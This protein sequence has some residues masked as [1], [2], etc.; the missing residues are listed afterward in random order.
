MVPWP[1][2]K[3]ITINI[4][5]EDHPI[6]IGHLSLPAGPSPVIPIALESG[7]ELVVDFEGA[8]KER[9][10]ASLQRFINGSWYLTK[11]FYSLLETAGTPRLAGRLPGGLYRFTSDWD[12]KKWISPSFLVRPEE[13]RRRRKL[14][15]AVATTLRGTVTVPKDYHVE[16]VR[17]LRVGP[18][19]AGDFRG[20]RTGITSDARGRFTVHTLDSDS[21]TIQPWHPQL[22]PLEEQ[23]TVA[24]DPATEPT[25]LLL[26]GT[27]ASFRPELPL[28][29]RFLT[30]GRIRVLLLHADTDRIV[31]THEARRIGDR[32]IFG[33]F[34]PGRY[35]VWIDP[36]S[37]LKWREGSY[38]SIVRLR[39]PDGPATYEVEVVVSALDQ[40]R[41]VRRKRARGRSR[42]IVP[43]LR[44]GRFRVSLERPNGAGTQV[45][46]QEITSPG[47]GAVEVV[48]EL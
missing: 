15:L 47:K 22:V 43:G 31:S 29:Q 6:A 28:P 10:S 34:M 17:I 14:N 45:T 19:N 44:A 1:N 32:F 16:D 3:R 40:P 30:D 18:T 35:R 20:A 21:V 23:R 25:I 39:W 13:G 26:P 7:G 36:P 11:T 37:M 9:G 46:A 38:T 48:F 42:V 33:G 41:Y 5:S 8:T 27:Q 2:A 24:L 4:D 12:R